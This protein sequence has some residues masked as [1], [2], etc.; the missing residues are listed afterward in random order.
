VGKGRLNGSLSQ[1]V[2]LWVVLCHIQRIHSLSFTECKAKGVCPVDA[3]NAYRRSR[4]I[5]PFILQLGT[6]QIYIKTAVCLMD[7]SIHINFYPSKWNSSEIVV[8]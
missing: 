2:Q 3:T 8:V 1:K 7:V 4:G 5:A 6:R